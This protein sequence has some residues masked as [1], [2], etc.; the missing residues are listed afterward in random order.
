MV[1]QS[2]QGAARMDFT[3]LRVPQVPTALE[4]WYISLVQFLKKDT[5]CSQRVKLIYSV[6]FAD[7]IYRQQHV[8]A[9]P[10]LPNWY[11]LSSP[12]PCWNI[13]QL[14]MVEWD[15]AVP[16][17][18]S[19]VLLCAD[20]YGPSIRSSSLWCWVNIYA[21]QYLNTVIWQ[22][23]THTLLSCASQVH[24]CIANDTISD[25]KDL[26]SITE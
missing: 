22:Q 3:A 20:C 8:P 7:W 5:M 9:W 17:V 15:R 21:F 16:A 4:M 23:Y 13:L 25:V 24:S 19:W 1:F 26:L 18:S 2:L 10:L 11:R 14:P 12:M 6:W